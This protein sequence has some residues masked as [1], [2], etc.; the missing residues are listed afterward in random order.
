M[1]GGVCFPHTLPAWEGLLRPSSP[2][3][4]RPS[5]RSAPLQRFSLPDLPSLLPQEDS[6]CLV[7]FQ[8]VFPPTNRELISR[9]T[10]SPFLASPSPPQPWGLPSLQGSP[11]STSPAPFQDAHLEGWS[12]LSSPLLSHPLRLSSALLGSHLQP[13]LSS[14]ALSS[15]PP[16][17]GAWL[18][19]TPALAAP[20]V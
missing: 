12:L 1:G 8:R 5:S 6:Q 3:L 11:P 17:P 20:P 19:E 7:S 16:S 15:H 10:S 13:L 9:R 14:P 2:H 18:F 4:P